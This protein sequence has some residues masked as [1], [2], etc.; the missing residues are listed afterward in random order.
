MIRDIM[1]KKVPEK[2]LRKH[3][4]GDYVK[5]RVPDIDRL[6]FD[7]RSLPCKILQQKPGI[8]SYQVGCAFG[9][10]NNWYPANELEPLDN[11]DMSE[12][13][14]IPLDST[15]SL[16]SAAIAQNDGLPRIGNLD[17]KGKKRKSDTIATPP[18]TN[19]RTKPV[20][21][22]CITTNCS[23]LRC[24]CRKGGRLCTRECGCVRR[25]VCENSTGSASKK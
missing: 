4:I 16:R 5:L 15:I 7:Q 12:L 19:Q 24:S 9:I 3:K 22:Q 6:K 10:L 13:V 2:L 21:C 25:R 17:K 23:T 11:P 1:M 8:D 18:S 14:V 20:F